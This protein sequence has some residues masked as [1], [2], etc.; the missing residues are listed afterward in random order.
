M[1]SARALLVVTVLVA[2]PTAWGVSMRADPAGPS[3]APGFRDTVVLRGLAE[4]LGV[5]FAPDGRMFVAEKAGV[6]K[7]FTSLERPASRVFADLGDRVFT[8]GDRGLFAVALDP[9]FPA[10]PYVYVLYTFDGPVG[11]PEPLRRG[12]CP[13]LFTGGCP[14][15]GRV[16]RLSPDGREVVLVSGWCQQY[17]SHGVGDLGFG[18]DGTLYASGGEGASYERVDSGDSRNV[19]GDPAGEGGALRAQ[20]LRTESDPAG[21]SGSVIAID[22][23]AGRH[24]VVAYGLRSPFRFALRPDEPELWIGDVGSTRADELNVVDARAARPVNL[25]WPCYEGSSPLRSY[26]ESDLPICERLYDDET[27]EAPAVV[28]PRAEEVIGGDGCGEGTQALSGLAFYRGG[29]Y[30]AR[31]RGA[32]FFSDYVRRCIW[33]LLPG[34]DGEPDADRVELFRSGLSAPVDLAVGP[35]GDLFYLDFAAGALHR[36]SYT[37]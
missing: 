27:A 25:G 18:S 8:D 16:S 14:V 36:L 12:S 5:A 13:G 1:L 17:P 4:P 21:L 23:E 28:L 11:A 33:V 20:D 3:P 15:S 9:R 19:C 29:A 6:I 32:L 2:V 7:E 30:P 22:V 34:E 26:D 37:G 10:R 35:G 24:R 31:Y